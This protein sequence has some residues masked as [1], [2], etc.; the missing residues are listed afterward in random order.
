MF[1][2]FYFTFHISLSVYLSPTCSLT[3]SLSSLSVV[4]HLLCYLLP[5]HALTSR[6][7]ANISLALFLILSSKLKAFCFVFTTSE[8]ILSFSPFSPFSPVSS[9]PVSLPLRYNCRHSCAQQQTSRL[10]FFLLSF[11]LQQPTNVD[12]RYFF[13]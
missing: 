7:G 12:H 5:C 11:M 10:L 13:R 4:R 6:Y 3:P 8:L 1:S 9:I 2:L